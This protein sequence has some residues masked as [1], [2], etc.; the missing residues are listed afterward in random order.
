MLCENICSDNEE[1]QGDKL[2]GNNLVNVKVF[3]TNIE[4]V[5]VFEQCVQEDDIQMKIDQ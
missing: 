2:T 5:L 1:K 4:K 3:T